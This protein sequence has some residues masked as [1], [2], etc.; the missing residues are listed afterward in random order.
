[1][2]FEYWDCNLFVTSKRDKRR[3]MDGVASSG[4]SSAGGKSSRM[5]AAHIRIFQ[6]P[7]GNIGGP[8]RNR[9]HG[10]GIMSSQEP[11]GAE[12]DKTFSSAKQGKVRQKLQP[13]RNPENEKERC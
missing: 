13:G 11:T 5:S 3:C 9:T 12:E 10:L 6:R 2:R 7:V 8:A 4:R 1:M